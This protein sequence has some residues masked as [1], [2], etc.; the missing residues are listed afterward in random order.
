[1]NN[2]NVKYG[3]NERVVSIDSLINTFDKLQSFI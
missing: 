1:M 3:S 2:D